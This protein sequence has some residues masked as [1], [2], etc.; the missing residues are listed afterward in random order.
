[1]NSTHK[2][3][4]IR[5][6]EIRKHPNADTL[7]LVDVGGYQIVVKLGEFLEGQLAIYVQPDSVLPDKPEFEW[8][9]AP[10]AYEGGTP[11]KKRRVTVRKF[12]KEWSEGLLLKIEDYAYEYPH[13]QGG[14]PIW[15]VEG[16]DVSEC[17]GITHYSPPEPGESERG[18]SV[19]Q[20][21]TRPRSLKGWFW[22][23][24]QHAAYY[25]SL[26][27]YSPWGNVGGSNETAP[28]NTPPIYDVEAFKNFKN[29]FVD[30][31]DVIV[32]EKIHGSNAR[33]LYQAN[34]FG[35]KMY[36][37]SRKLWKS[38]NSK[39]VWREAIKQNRWIEE[40]CREHPGYTLYGE[41]TPTQGGFNYGCENGQ[42]KFFVF[43]ILQPNGTWMDPRSVRAAGLQYVPLFYSG[44]FD[45]SLIKGFVDGQSTVDGAKHIREGIVIKTAVERITHGLGRAQLKIVSN[46]YLEKAAA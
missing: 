1:M 18:P 24:L 39:C 7:G 4:V 45:E 43:D 5:L 35:G 19:K 8:F 22:Y 40:W 15:P 29:T 9:W 13:D 12:R 32:T 2:V 25:G 46:K 27:L 44:P 16:E 26:T 38:E 30:G 42:V 33:F 36:A 20:S 21:K 34:T 37:G 17:L 23:I 28:K 31:E 10:N 3:N 6:G 14:F 11:E 41:V